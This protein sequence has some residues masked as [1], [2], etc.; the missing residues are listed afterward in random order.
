M[1]D[2]HPM[3]ARTQQVLKMGIV[4]QNK[5]KPQMLHNDVINPVYMLYLKE[6]EKQSRQL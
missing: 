5:Y 3:R 4:Y 2:T 1:D 6:N